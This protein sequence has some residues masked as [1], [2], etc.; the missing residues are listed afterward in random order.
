MNDEE[1]AL[2]VELIAGVIQRLYC[3][4]NSEGLYKN[5]AECVMSELRNKGWKI[6]PPDKEES[7]MAYG[8]EERFPSERAAKDFGLAAGSIMSVTGTDDR[9]LA[10]LCVSNISAYICRNIAD[11]AKWIRP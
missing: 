10:E 11:R 3:Y 7:P 5:Q 2:A 6:L 9:K 4:A 1:H 8:P